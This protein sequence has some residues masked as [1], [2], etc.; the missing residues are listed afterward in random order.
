MMEALR[1]KF[2]L[3]CEEDLPVVRNGLSDPSF[4]LVVHRLAGVA[5]MFGFD[6]LGQAALEVDDELCA[7]R[8]PEQGLVDAVTRALEEALDS[9]KTP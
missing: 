4:K 9:S 5:P 2:L 7:A 1:E 3:R 6:A 8:A